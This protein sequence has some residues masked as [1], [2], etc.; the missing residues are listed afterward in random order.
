MVEVEFLQGGKSLTKVPMQLPPADAHG[1]IPYVM[2]IPAQ[3]IPAGVYE[4]RAA[5]RQGAT[6]AKSETNITFE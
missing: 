6:S 1:R 3:A 2:T 4:V 5:V